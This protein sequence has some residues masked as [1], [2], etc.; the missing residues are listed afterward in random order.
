MILQALQEY[1]DR[2]TKV[3]N[4]SVAPL[5]WEL[6]EIPYIVALDTE[7]N[8]RDVTCTIE[9][10]GKKKTIK[11]F[12]VPQ[13]VKR[14]S[15]VVANLLWDNPEYV[16]GLSIKKKD[17]PKSVKK[18]AAFRQ[19]IEELGTSDDPGIVALK[20][21]LDFTLEEKIE[22]LDALNNENWETLKKDS[23]VNVTFKLFG[24]ITASASL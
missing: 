24:E 19:K 9:G 13:A 5:G 18:Q 1:Y 3:P 16:F 22:K 4:S 10:S 2:K 17:D 8:P 21:F 15:N 23:A 12:Y 20:K 11:K 14:A 7:G 6:K